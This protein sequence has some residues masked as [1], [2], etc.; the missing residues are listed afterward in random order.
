MTESGAAN[1]LLASPRAAAP[2]E[3]SEKLSS[4][5]SNPDGQSTKRIWTRRRVE[6]R[7]RETGEVLYEREHRSEDNTGFY[8]H[9]GPIYDVVTVYKTRP[10]N[11][12]TTIEEPPP[13]S[14]T[15]SHSLRIYSAAII[16]ALQSIVQYYP[17]QDLTGDAI[18]MPWPYPI[19]VH[20]FDELTKFREQCMAKPSSQLCVRE[21]EVPEHLELLLRFLDTGIMVDVRAEQERNRNG[22]YTWE[23]YWVAMKPGITILQSLREK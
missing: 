22:F 7:H 14:S 15:P 6:Y 16:H 8:S 20:H 2:G 17:G 21:R 12:K 1:G 23:G 10:L 9:D 19:L 18:D 5:A 4:P 11:S 3:T 13:T